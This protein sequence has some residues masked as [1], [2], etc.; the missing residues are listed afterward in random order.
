MKLQRKLVIALTAA[1]ACA[2]VPV[3]AAAGPIA[4]PNWDFSAGSSGFSS[5]YAYLDVTTAA[6]SEFGL[7]WPEG[8]YAVGTDPSL[9][10]CL[11]PSFGDHTTGDGNMLIVNGSR[12]A[13][14]VLWS[15]LVDVAPDSYYNFSAWVTSVYPDNLASLAFY[16][17]GVMVSA[18]YSS[19]ATAG[20][21]QQFNA[22]WNSGGQT[23]AILSIVDLNTEA[24]GNDFAIDDIEMSTVPDGGTSLLL[25][26]GA[27]A[28]LGALRRKLGV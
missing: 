8:T 10:H 3:G 14:V 28:G 1:V 6:F 21:W 27:L 20:L 13:G 12:A 9:Y 7:L 24:H 22:G 19:D 25:L 5:D 18:P 23:T 16:I 11:W 4:I 17:N 15:A 26:G 2:V